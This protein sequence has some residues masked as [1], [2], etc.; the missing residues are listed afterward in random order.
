MVPLSQSPAATGSGASWVR[1][2]GVA[3]FNQAARVVIIQDLRALVEKVRG[4]GAAAP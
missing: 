4:G 2:Y 1:G 3:G